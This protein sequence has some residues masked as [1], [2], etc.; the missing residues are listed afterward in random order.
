MTPTGI[1]PATLQLV[2]QCLN[3]VRPWDGNWILVLSLLGLNNVRFLE[4]Q[5]YLVADRR[6]IAKCLKIQ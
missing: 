3:Q 4:E 1:E 5:I 2:V 6:T